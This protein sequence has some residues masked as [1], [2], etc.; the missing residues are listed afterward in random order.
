MSSDQFRRILEQ[1]YIRINTYHHVD[2][3]KK[4][5]S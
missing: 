3:Y 4:I 2:V 1:F 5:L